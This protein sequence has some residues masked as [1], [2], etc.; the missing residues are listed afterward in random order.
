[1]PSAVTRT[2][3][4]GNSE[5]VRLPKGIGFGEGVE[6]S[7]ERTGN[8]V[9]L[10]PVHGDRPNAALVARLRALTNPGDPIGTRD[11]FDDAER[12]GL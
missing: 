6:L 10:R 12:P 9:T 4:N 8:I 2:F 3:R 11:P 7:V 5:A 1:M